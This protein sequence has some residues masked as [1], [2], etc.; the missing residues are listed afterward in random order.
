MYKQKSRIIN[1]RVTEEELT[2]LKAASRIHG[3]KCLSDFARTAILGT[4]QAPDPANE[5]DGLVAGKIQSLDCRLSTVES[6]LARV[7]NMLSFA[8]KVCR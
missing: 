7:L 6:D 2:R 3:A 8:G 1:F 4:V 5:A